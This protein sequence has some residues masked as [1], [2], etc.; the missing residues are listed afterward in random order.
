VVNW[1][2]VLK[3][4]MDIAQGMRFMHNF[5]PP[6]IHRDLKS[7]NVLLATMLT[8][9]GY[10]SVM[11][12]VADFGFSR[13]LMFSQQLSSVGADNPVW[14]APEVIQREAYDGKADV[15][16]YGVILWELVAREDFLKDILS[17]LAIEQAVLQGERPPIPEDCLAKCPELAS[18]IVRCW[19]AEPSARPTFSE[20]CEELA[21]IT[22]KQLPIIGD[23]LPPITE[24]D[25]EPSSANAQTEEPIQHMRHSQPTALSSAVICNWRPAQPKRNSAPQ[26]FLRGQGDDEEPGV[27]TGGWHRAAP[28][29]LTQEFVGKDEDELEMGTNPPKSREVS[30]QGEI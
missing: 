19:A 15:Y 3:L 11:A 26:A 16:S 12:K 20:I 29:H 18:L 23:E 2:V 21:A 8:D 13:S 6:L 25:D 24:T 5:E 10:P 1:A 4:A 28:K 22:E 17:P 14:L 7:P 9:A 27:R 30:R